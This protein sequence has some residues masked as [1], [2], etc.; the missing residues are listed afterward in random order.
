MN[1]KIEKI[2]ILF[3]VVLMALYIFWLAHPLMMDD[4][5]QYE[6]FAESLA[7]GH[8]DF[9]SF[10]GFQGLSIL[11]VPIFWL[12]HSHISIIITSS[13]LYLLSI[14]LAYF[15]GRDYY[16]NKRAG[17]YLMSLVL[18]IPY[19]YTTMMRGF[20]ESAVLFFVLLIIWGSIKKK[21]WAPL[22]WGFGGIVKP[23]ALVLF[24]LFTRDVF[25]KRKAGWIW[26][27]VA[28]AIGGIYLGLNYHQTGHLINDAAINSYQ[29]GT[30]DQAQLALNKSFTFGIKGFLRIAANL[31]VVSRKILISPLVILLGAWV[32]LSSEKIRLKKEILFAVVSN[33]LLV[34]S[35]TF[36]FPKYLL[37][38]VVLLALS[39][40]PL[41]MRY[42]W[43]MLVVFADSL[44]VMLPIYNY[45]GHNFWTSLSL[46]LI[47]F[48]LAI[49][50][51]IVDLFFKKNQD[52]RYR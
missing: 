37:P 19:T 13:I 24:P 45:F 25:T 26:L 5:V 43:L 40:I 10:Y 31:F 44:M 39:A 47:P 22:A 35:L 41:L 14:I 52:V 32:L 27:V 46:F 20:Q 33:I 8:L 6:G 48:Y 2:L 15:V 28:L 17:L 7:H 9:K 21:I 49:I 23:F 34:G 1:S 18:L 50:V 3:V 11:S 51:F 42:P 29:P 36:S 12:T 4:G 30:Y 38:M 16:D